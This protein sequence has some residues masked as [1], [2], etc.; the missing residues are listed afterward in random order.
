MQFILFLRDKTYVCLCGLRHFE[1][2]S[3]Y[4]VALSFI[5]SVGSK[6]PV[7]LSDGVF[8]SVHSCTVIVAD[9]CLFR[10]G[11]A[12]KLPCHYVG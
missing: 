4:G 8:R 2:N 5:S 6:T 12:N 9:G 11:E 3:V 1:L 7:A 10:Y